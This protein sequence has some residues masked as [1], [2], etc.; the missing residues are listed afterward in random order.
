MDELMSLIDN[1]VKDNVEEG[2]YLRMCN[3]MKEIHDTKKTMCKVFFSVPYI[4]NYY[5][6]ITNANTLNHNGIYLSIISSYTFME[7]DWFLEM[8]NALTQMNF[9]HIDDIEQYIL[10]HEYI[11][12][13]QKGDFHNLTN[14]LTADTA[15][16][17]LLTE[18][19][20]REIYG[21]MNILVANHS[22]QIVPMKAFDVRIEKVVLC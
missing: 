3:K 10:E 19:N 20:I 21:H 14:G 22:N 16:Y 18:K 6:S 4:R 1:E 17:G 13:I 7:F 15:R 11:P 8:I 9:D 2:L 12:Y 5:S